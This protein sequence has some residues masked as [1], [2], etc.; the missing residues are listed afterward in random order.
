MVK[1]L[2]KLSMFR[3][4]KEFYNDPERKSLI[5]ILTEIIFLS[6][7]NLRLSPRYY[8]GRFL[9]KRERKNIRDFFPGE[10]FDIVNRHFND[11]HARE[12]LENKL[13]F[14][15]FYSQFNVP[16]PR[17]LAYNH[18]NIFV[19]DG[20]ISEINNPDDL[21]TFL[22]MLAGKIPDNDSIFIKPT[23]GTWG[24]HHV[25]KI[26]KSQISDEYYDMNNLYN[27]IRSSQY[28]FQEKV[29][30][31]PSLN[32]FNPSCLNTMRIDTFID[33]DG[34]AEVMSAYI[35]TS[36]NGLHVD[37]ISSG[38]CQIPIDMATGKLKKHGHMH[39][40]NYGFSQPAE[41]PFTHVPFEDY[42][43]PYFEDVKRLVCRIAPYIPNLRLVGWDVAIGESGPVVI[44]G[45]SN[46][47]IAGCDLAYGGYRSNPVF[48]KALHEM[49]Y[50]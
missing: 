32:L 24:G 28:L 15:L 21:R 3:L 29:K 43:I 49:N 48:R 25:F 4:I 37:N 45:N 16:V 19:I 14:D 20:E 46:Y 5:R 2:P 38:G 39:I 18:K 13:F 42:T 9:F 41:H 35:R 17:L 50:F 10:F 23:W 27:E 34:K 22:Q 12:V 8:F 6:L 30:Q 44:E 47:E 11:D 1:T 36:V 26:L 33:K 7:V 31:H 40:M